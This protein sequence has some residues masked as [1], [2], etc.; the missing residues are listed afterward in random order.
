MIQIKPDATILRLYDLDGNYIGP[1]ERKIVFAG[2]IIDIDEYAAETGL[3]LP[4]STGE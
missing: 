3:V 2:E 1:A 4:D